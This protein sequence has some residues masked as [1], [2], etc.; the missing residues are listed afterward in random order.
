[1]VFGTRLGD[2]ILAKLGYGCFFESAVAAQVIP[3][4]RRCHSTTYNE[5]FILKSISNDRRK[6]SIAAIRFLTVLFSVFTRYYFTDMG[7]TLGF[8]FFI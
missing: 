8:L 2:L 5:Y 4:F 1:M 7:R 6:E 3:C